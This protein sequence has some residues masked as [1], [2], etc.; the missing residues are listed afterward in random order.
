MDS[1]PPLGSRLGIPNGEGHLRCPVQ[2]RG[3]CLPLPAPPTR[4][5]VLPFAPRHTRFEG[6]RH[7]GPW[8]LKACGI[9]LEP[10]GVE[11]SLI[12]PGVA[13]A[14]EDLPAPS[15]AEGQPGVGFLIAHQG[16]TGDDVVLAWWDAENELPLRVWAR[17]VGTGR[18]RP[19]RGGIR[20][21]CGTCG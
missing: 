17:D 8:R 7:A 16:R 5:P 3:L 14:L 4:A 21:A 1:L 13:L 9:S 11:W 20:C 18:F 12:E 6:L 2:G 19:A 10:R 15:A